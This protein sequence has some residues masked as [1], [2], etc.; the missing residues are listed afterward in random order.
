[1]HSMLERGAAALDARVHTGRFSTPDGYSLYYELYELEQISPPTRAETHERCAHTQQTMSV[2]H[3]PRHFCAS[4]VQHSASTRYG[5]DRIVTQ[6]G[7]LPLPRAS[8]PQPIVVQAE[9][10]GEEDGPPP[11][12]AAEEAAGTIH[13]VMIMGFAAGCHGWLPL[14]HQLKARVCAR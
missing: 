10:T 1:M 9:A 4:S 6:C 12:A 7:L 5:V 8:P 2:A 13:I 11:A 3:R 14:L